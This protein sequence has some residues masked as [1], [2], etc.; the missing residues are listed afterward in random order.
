[1]ISCIYARN[2]TCANKFGFE[3]VRGLLAGRFA[4][5]RDIEELWGPP[6]LSRPPLPPPSNNILEAAPIL[7][8]AQM[9]KAGRVEEGSK[10]MS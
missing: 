1:M 2:Q 5:L 3:Q 7:T 6:K 9:I 10:S 4:S 8:C